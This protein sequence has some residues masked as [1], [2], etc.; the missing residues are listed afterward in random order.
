M[1]TTARRLL[2]WLVLPNLT[3]EVSRCDECCCGDRP[4]RPAARRPRRRA[5][6]W[7]TDGPV[8]RPFSLGTD[9]T[10]AA[11]TAASTSAGAAGAAV[12]APSGEV[13]FAGTVPGERQVAD[14]PDRRRL[15]G[16]AH[17]SRLERASKKGDDGRRGRRRSA[18]SARAATPARRSRTSISASASPPIRTAT[19]DPLDFLPAR[20]A[21]PVPT[22]PAA[23]TR[24]RPRRRP[25]TPRRRC[26]RRRR[27]RRRRRRRRRPRRRP[28]R[29]RA[30][31]PVTTTRR[32]R[33]P[34]RR[35]RRPRSAPEATAPAATT[36]ARLRQPLRRPTRRCAGPAS[37]GGRRAGRPSYR[38]SPPAAAV[39]VAGDE[40][41]QAPLAAHRVLA[42]HGAPR[43]HPRC[44]APPTSRAA[45]AAPRGRRA[46]RPGL[47]ARAH[48]RRAAGRAGT[49]HAAPHA[50]ARPGRQFRRRRARDAGVLPCARAPA[51]AAAAAA[52]VAAAAARGGRRRDQAR[53]VSS[54][55]MTLLPDNADLLRELDAAHRPRVHDDRRRTSS[56]GISGSAGEDTFF[57]TG[58]DEH[59]TKV[60]RVAE[61]Q[62]LAPQ[63]YA[64]RIAVAW[65]ELPRPR[66][67]V[68]RLLH[69]DER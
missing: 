21:T 53:S 48:E 19:V 61:E 20:P 69:P 59:A 26:R 32:C 56:S 38:P 2:P 11:S 28:G 36:A 49:A 42:A 45:P 35:R 33:R 60:A 46:D 40:A 13:T 54:T 22:T 55:A 5:W 12:R 57:L 4:G 14:D 50:S 47:V 29:G 37:T 25:T 41:P 27:P 64:D 62:G 24:R 30:T 1:L 67:R 31:A 10:P 39:P 9:P 8:L 66:R 7:P 23:T 43:S 44:D 18:R 52:P 51:P 6:T 63:E 34:P 16:H 15:R 68:E 65:R 58:V 3:T 17:A